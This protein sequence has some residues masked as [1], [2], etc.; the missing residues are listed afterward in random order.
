MTTPATQ[1]TVVFQGQDI[2]KI[3]DEHGRDLLGRLSGN[4]RKAIGDTQE[5]P[6]V[7][8]VV[9][10]TIYDADHLLINE[11]LPRRSFLQ[12]ELGGGR[13]GSQGIAAN[14]D[15]VF[16]ATSCNQEFNLKRLE[17]FTTI[18][19][20]SGATPV[21]VLTKS[22]LATPAELADKID[23]LKNY[24]Y[25]LPVLVTTSTHDNRSVFAPYLLPGKVV[26][27]IGSSG[28]GKS[29]LLNQF[30]PADE[31]L[32]TNEI[33]LEDAHGK[34]TTTSRQLFILENG[35][36]IIDTP[37]MRAIGLGTVSS[38]SLE[39]VCETIVELGKT[40]RFSNCQHDTEPGCAIKHALQTGELTAEQF[41]SFK[42]FQAQLAYLKKKEA[43]KNK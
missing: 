5:I 33:R 34:H 39:K 42:K 43:R 1:G 24:F 27:L 35:A 2:F 16:I 40:C 36:Q 18:V 8:D 11:L 17:R 13:L 19:W 7:G 41:A 9:V 31:Q 23:Q 26:T 30:L 3:K 14:I 10:G 25:G 15:T 37:G 12:R 21:F 29:T 32:V 22:D 28:V 4:F 6:V 20:D 38:E